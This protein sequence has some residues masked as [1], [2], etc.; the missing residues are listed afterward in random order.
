MNNINKEKI[1]TIIKDSASKIKNTS[2][3][4][5]NQ[6]NIDITYISESQRFTVI[7][8]IN[9]NLINRSIFAIFDVSNSIIYFKE[10]E[11]FQKRKHIE[12]EYILKHKKEDKYK[13]VKIDEYKYDYLLKMNKGYKTISC[14]KV[15][16]EKI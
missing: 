11:L 2:K 13:I 12:K 1:L 5:I 4:V 3:E 8:D 6:T 14:Y 15:Y 9:Q 10:I 16:L 7:K